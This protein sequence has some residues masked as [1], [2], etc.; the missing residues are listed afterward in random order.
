MTKIA[1]KK[2]GMQLELLNVND[3]YRID[4]SKKVLGL[5][6]QKD[7]V[8]FVPLERTCSLFIGVDESGLQKD[9]STNFLLSM[10]NPHFPIQKMVGDVVFVRIKQPES[11]G[12]IYDY[13]IVDLTSNDIILINKI[14]D[15]HYQGYLKSK[16]QDYGRGYTVCNIL[17]KPPFQL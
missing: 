17:D 7:Y 10:N 12:E 8:E 2:V 9:L 15:I 14:L 6:L 5:D 1:R 13:E 3:K 16:F 4:C 11:P